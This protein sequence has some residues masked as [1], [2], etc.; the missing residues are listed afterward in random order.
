MWVDVIRDIIA[1]VTFFMPSKRKDDVE[2]AGKV[3]IRQYKRSQDVT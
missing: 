1:Y 3:S 2:A